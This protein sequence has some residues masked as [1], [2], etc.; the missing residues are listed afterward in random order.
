MNRYQIHTGRWGVLIAT[1]LKVEGLFLILRDVERD[2]K[3]FHLVCMFPVHDV[4]LIIPPS[5]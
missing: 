3:P 5:D 1:T 2:G 4:Q